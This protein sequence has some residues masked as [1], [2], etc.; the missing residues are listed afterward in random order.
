MLRRE[1]NLPGAILAGIL[2][3]VWSELVYFAP[4]VLTEVLAG[5]CLLLGILFGES[6]DDQRTAR[7][8]LIGGALF[9]LVVCL[10]YQYAPALLAIALWQNRLDVAPLGLAG[11]W[12]PCRGHPHRRRP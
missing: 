3:A 12:R 9:G 2:C 4:A 7:R 8:L 6:G 10:R 5:N 11:R 1:E